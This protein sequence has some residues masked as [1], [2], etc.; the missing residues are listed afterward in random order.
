MS[1]LGPALVTTILLTMLPATAQEVVQLD[2][3]SMNRAG[4]LVRPVLERNFGEQVPVFGEV[5]RS[6]GTTLT[7]KT[8]VEGRVLELLAAPGDLVLAGEPLLRVHSHEVHALQGELLSARER[9]RLA[10]SRQEAGEQLYALEGIS[11]IEL[12]QRSQD[13]MAAQIDYD[14][15]LHELEDIGLSSQDLD[16]LLQQGRVDG[17]L[18]LYAL[19]DGVVLEMTVQQHQWIQAFEPLMVLGDPG[20]LELRV[21]IPP[22]DASRVGVGDQIDFVPVGRPDA[23]SLARV[24]TPIPTV[25]PVTRTVA[26]R[27]E[28]VKTPQPLF[29]GVFIEGMLTHGESRRSPSVPESAVIRIGGA[30]FVFVQI[31]EPGSFEA[32]PVELGHFNGT[33]YEV[34]R[35][36]ALDEQV[37][38]QGVFFLKSALLQR[39]VEE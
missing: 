39:Q 35:G 15:S 3:A 1:R 22:A 33:R 17:Q 5:V 36:V 2:A 34:L 30:D 18:V 13:A 21:K 9:L 37:V 24:L 29:P 6:P 32:R 20:R 23:T 38:V 16:R 31:D 12:E 4:V 25:D 27:A 28:I 8:P 14:V 11:R 26:V 7:V 19:A 10:R